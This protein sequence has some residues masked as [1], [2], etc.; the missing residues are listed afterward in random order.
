MSFTATIKKELTRLDSESCCKKAEL[1]A[2]VRINGTVHIRKKSFMIDIV[3][4]NPSTARYIF[5]LVKNLYQVQ[6]EVLVRK[7]VRLKKNNVYMI[8]LASNANRIL[9]DLYIMKGNSWERIEGIAP[10]LIKRPCCKRAYLRGAFL[11]SGSV[12]NP[13]SASYHLEIVSTY[14]DHSQSLCQLMNR[15]YLHAKVIERKKG[16]VVYIKEGDKIGEFLN[17]IGAHP[18]LLKFE[19][20]RIM[21]D[22]RNSVNRLVNCETANLNKTIQAAMRQIKNIQRIDQEIGLEHLPDRLRE[23]AETRLKYPEAN[24][25]ELGQ[26]LPSGKV[27]KSAINHRLRKLEEIA[28]KFSA[29]NETKED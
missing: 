26:L 19:N 11:A 24:L 20:V 2:L 9:E 5:S 13:D 22:M 1:S 14:H 29:D 27:S 16:F 7:K 17:I 6:P 28:K 25:A 10:E 21:K 4:E 23:V 18:S 15:F 12:N 8:R 3:T